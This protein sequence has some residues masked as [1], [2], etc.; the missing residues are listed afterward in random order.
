MKY[1]V[2]QVT[3]PLCTL[4]SKPRLPEHCIEYVKL[5][6]WS[7]EKPFGGEREGSK[8]GDNGIDFKIV[9]KVMCGVTYR[10]RI[11]GR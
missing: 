4:A 5:L 6:L 3:Y 1:L 7:K 11:P 2:S 8:V 10:G 9:Q